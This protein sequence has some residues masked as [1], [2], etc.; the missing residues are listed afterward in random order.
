MSHRILVLLFVLIA[1]C[2]LSYYAGTR[3]VRSSDVID[4]SEILKQKVQ[5]IVDIDLA[6][7]NRLKDREKQ[8]LKAE[9][10]LGKVMMIF[11]ADLGIRVSKQDLSQL[12]RA[13]GPESPPRES[14]VESTPSARAE[15]RKKE[16]P[17]PKGTAQTSSFVELEQRIKEIFNEHDAKEFGK[18][19][20]VDNLFPNIK[21]ARVM[22]ASALEYMNGHFVGEVDYDNTVRKSENVSIELSAAQNPDGKVEGRYKILVGG[23]EQSGSGGIPDFS[24]MEGGGLLI[25]ASPT[26]YLQ[27]YY[28][29]QLDMLVGN[30]YEQKGSIDNF[31]KVASASLHRR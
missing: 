28:I 23:H 10:M 24:S 21:S 19:L 30:M 12:A 31:Q 27:L 29:R 14:V 8:Y 15:S 3:S 22:D 20:I 4:K 16:P 25:K 1:A 9:E 13:A 7:Y 2:A 18:S 6:E 5:Q 26:S 11:L 17:A